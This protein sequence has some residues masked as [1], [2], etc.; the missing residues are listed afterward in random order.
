MAL[1][2]NGYNT[3]FNAFV[4]FAQNS[5]VTNDKTAVA[6]FEVGGAPRNGARR[7]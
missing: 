3:D 6:R 5:F 7:W 4:K 2:I 1:D